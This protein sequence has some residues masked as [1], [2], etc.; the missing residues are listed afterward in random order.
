MWRDQVFSSVTYTDISNV[1]VSIYVFDSI[2]REYIDGVI[3]LTF[4]GSEDIEENRM[5]TSSPETF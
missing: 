1:G 4:F 2:G 3:S 5:Q